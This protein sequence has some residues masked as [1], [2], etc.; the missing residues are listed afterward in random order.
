MAGKLRV[1]FHCSSACTAHFAVT[2]ALSGIQRL[3]AVPVTLAR[4]TGH[5][6]RAGVGQAT[7]FFT[8]AARGTLS[9]VGKLVI[10]GY[11]VRA[12]SSPSPP[13]TARLTITREVAPP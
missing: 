8:R 7:L 4:G 11:A 10:S 5:L 3:A 13:R 6:G 1:S 12:N 9:R 2:V